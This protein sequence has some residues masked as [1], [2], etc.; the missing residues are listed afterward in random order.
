MTLARDALACRWKLSGG[1]GNVYP[2]AGS[3]TCVY[4]SMQ[5]SS[6]ANMQMAGLGFCTYISC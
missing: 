5:S 2:F 4:F 1:T 6:Y 3:Q